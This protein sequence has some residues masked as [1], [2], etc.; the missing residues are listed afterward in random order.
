[1]PHSQIPARPLLLANA[2]LID[3]SRNLDARGDLLMIDGA[4]R[5]SGP[6][7]AAAGAPDG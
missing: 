3:P 2:R 4:I 7:L 1:M 6:G 5:D